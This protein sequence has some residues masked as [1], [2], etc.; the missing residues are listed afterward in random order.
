M[1]DFVHLHVHSEFSLLDGLARIEDLIER[2]CE[3]D[4]PALALTDHGV[5]Y[6]AIRFY[7]RAVEAGIRPILGMEAYVARRSR[8][9]KSGRRDSSPFHLTLLARNQAGY[10][11]LI[12]LASLAQ[13][14][15][16]YYKPRVDRELLEAHAEGLICLSGCRS[17]EV[18]RL[19]AAGRSEEAR[20]AAAWHREVFGSENFYVELQEH[21][22]EGQRELNR[23]LVEL[24]EGLG[25]PL[26]ATNDVHY[27]RAENAR[28]HDILLCI[29]TNTVV[30]DP[31]RMRMDDAGFYLKSEA[32]MAALFAERPEALS[33][34]RR[35]AERI[36]L[37]IDFGQ[38]HLPAF[39]VP[40]GLSD[41]AYLEELARRGLERRYRQVTAEIE[42]RLA[43]ELDVIRDLGLAS[44]MLLVW[45]FIREA[46][47]R[48]ITVGPGRGSAPSS[49]ISYCL[50]ITNVDPLAHGLLFERFLSVS[51]ERTLEAAHFGAVA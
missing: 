51:R 41:A 32:E 39:P 45:D 40:E 31:K 16:F 4:M 3:L 50:G 35:I 8:H 5:M 42:D 13:L 47:E 30:D 22:I 29:Q 18:P 11:N 14:E 38:L 20:Q 49:L 19:L 15:G 2:A 17:A 21:E 44:Y 1:A 43:Y 23:A 36:A 6:G 37:E 27:A 24:A 12:R 33:N 10:R 25:A 26:V 9:H 7:A 46:R 34:T 48:G 28:A